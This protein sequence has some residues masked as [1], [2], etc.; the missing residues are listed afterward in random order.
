MAEVKSPDETPNWGSTT[1]L[2]IGMTFVAF[3][4]ALLVRFRGIIGPLIL[5][6]VLTY[7][8]YPVVSF[9]HRASKLSWRT[10]AGVLF[11]F[12]MIIY[13]GLI[14]LTG[15]TVVQ[16][17]Q[18]LI[19]F[20]V[21]RVNDIPSL[22][23]NLSSQV[24]KIGI[25]EFSLAQFD[26]QALSEQLLAVVQPLLG[27][28]GGLI[29]TF[30]T[31]AAVTLGWSLFVI[32]ISYFLLADAGRVPDRL[33]NI[34]IPGY[35][36]DVRRIGHELRKIW[37]AY[38]RGQLIIILL[39]IISYTVLMLILGLR[40][41]IGIAILAGLARFV[42]YIGPITSSIVTFLVAFFQGGNYFGLEPFWYAVVVLVLA[43]IVDQIY[44]N[45]ISPRLLGDRLGLHPAAVLV[46]AIIA[47]NLIGI[48][49]LMLAAPVLATFNLLGRYISRKMFDLEP[50]PEEDAIVKS[51]EGPVAR[52]PRILKGW[53]RL[54]RQRSKGNPPDR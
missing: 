8:L 31:S 25:F 17:L 24:Y 40:F 10:S 35:D 46:A 23:A 16:Q 30:A 4:A 1:K 2:I 37:N 44:D 54:I 6:F 39:V 13:A 48:I 12:V 42:P 51:V 33:V 20:I 7:L 53:W 50:W 45:L 27:R 14:T 18:N 28:M 22:A 36:Y 19:N 49:G 52:L 3:V 29:S 43:F 21:L 41:A 26:L 15:L 5:A 9:I 32:L 11:I 38:L 47:A 34:E